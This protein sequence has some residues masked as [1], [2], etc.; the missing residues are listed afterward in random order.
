MASTI[1]FADDDAKLAQQLANPVASLISVP[2][3]Y[4]YDDKYGVTDEGSKHLINVQP[5]IPFSISDSYNVI[6]RTILPVVAHSES[7]FGGG[8]T[9]GL[10]DTL[11]SFFFSPKEPTAGGLIWGAGPAF[12][13]PTATDKL[14]GA[15]KWGLGPTAVGLR[16]HGAW[17]YGGLIN[18]LWSIAGDNSRGD[19]NASFMQPFVSYITTTKT[20]FTLN[21]ESTYDWRDSNWSVPVNLM[22][23][24]LF[25]I[26]DQPMQ[27]GVGPRYWVEAPEGGPEGWGARAVFTLLFPR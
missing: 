6:S 13:L 3:Q 7:V 5:V 24:Q 21:S 9:G 10:G 26:G 20:T 4:N 8:E 22:V 18:H 15:E 25:K 1:C 16:Q 11:Q 14:L 27:L 12:L 2:M 19:V 17:T 23:S